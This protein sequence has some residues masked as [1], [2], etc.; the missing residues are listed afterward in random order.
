M[1]FK[2]PDISGWLLK[3]HNERVRKKAKLKLWFA[4]FPVIVSCNGK[5]VWLE[6]IWRQG[7]CDKRRVYYGKGLNDFYSGNKYYIDKWDYIARE[8][9]EPQQQQSV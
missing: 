4:W 9:Y 1:Q 3:K 6:V 8:S 7:R 2:C 5:C